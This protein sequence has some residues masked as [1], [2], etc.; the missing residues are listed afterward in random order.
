MRQPQTCLQSWSYYQPKI[1][2]TKQGRIKRMKG[3]KRGKGDG[4]RRVHRK[5]KQKKQTRGSRR[6]QTKTHTAKTG[7]KQR[8]EQKR[9][10]SP[11]YTL[12]DGGKCGGGGVN[13]G[14]VVVADATVAV[15]EALAVAGDY[16]EAPKQ[17]ALSFHWLVPHHQTFSS[18]IFLLSSSDSF[19]PSF[20]LD[21]SFFSFFYFFGAIFSSPFHFV[22]PL[23]LTNPHLY[24]CYLFYVP[25]PHWLF[26]FR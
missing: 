23:L 26:Y 24:H 15:A 20:F 3:D 6:K 2:V 13:G 17:F 19:P 22:I 12:G 7:D 5:R 21:I 1:K 9:R 18:F 25:F 16:Q 14:G 8:R 10:K 4:I 11:F